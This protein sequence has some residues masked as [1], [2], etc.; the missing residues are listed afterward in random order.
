MNENL[1]SVELYSLHENESENTDFKADD[2]IENDEK[3]DPD[4]WLDNINLRDGDDIEINEEFDS[5]KWL[6][7]IDFQ[8]AES[9][10]EFDPDEWI[11]DI[12]LLDGN[13]D[14]DNKELVPKKEIVGTYNPEQFNE[15][16]SD[17]NNDV[18]NSEDYAEK[19]EENEEENSKETE[20]Q[21]ESDEKDSIDNSVDDTEIE[22]NSED[23]NSEKAENTDVPEKKG[24]IKNKQDGLEREKKVEEEL[25]EKYPEEE[26]YEVISEAYLRDENG[27]IVKDPV[28]GEARR[29]DFVVVKD[30]KVVDS[31]EVTSKTADK[32]E[33]SAKEQRI[34]ENGGNYI[35]DSNGNLVGMPS[36]ITTKIE[37]RD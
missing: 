8:K 23:E 12:Y 24:P 22:R 6:D 31:V 14:E 3:F 35:K 21:D 11:D 36:D 10:E 32:T 15:L 4:V 34:R 2:I 18:D 16:T 1:D 19:K 27:N 30:G 33:Q 5:D 25:K 9:N 26:G 28:T 17:M 37:R 7:N 13:S 20:N 29:I